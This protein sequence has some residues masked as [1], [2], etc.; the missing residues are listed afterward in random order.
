MK[1]M[2]KTATGIGLLVVALAWAG[3]EWLGPTDD[4]GVDRQAGFGP[5]AGGQAVSGMNPGAPNGQ[6]WQQPPPTQSVQPMQAM[7][8]QRP[9]VAPPLDTRS[10]QA[11]Q[12]LDLGISNPPTVAIQLQIPAGWSPVGGI[13]WNDQT[14]CGGNQ[15]QVNWIALAPDSLT[16][17]EVL[18]GFTWQVAGTEQQFN[19]CPVA[20]LRSAREFLEA[21][22]RNL[23]PD[24]QLV[25]YQDV[26]P[27]PP[28]ANEPPPAP[29]AQVRKEGGRL[30]IAYS[31]NGIAM[32]EILSTTV[33]F[34]SMQ[35]SVM[36]GAGMV[37]ALRAPAGRLDVGLLN[38]I[39]ASA[40]T[41]P[42]WLAAVNERVR[43]SVERHHAGVTA[44]IDDWHNREMATINARG[45]AERHA[46]RM[47][48]NQEVA[49]IYS[50]IAANTSATN[51]GIHRR[52]LE[53][54]GEYNTFN[55]TNG[56][57]VQNSIHNGQRVFQDT[58]N[59]NNTF[60]TNQPYFNPPGGYVEL[61]RRR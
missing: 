58:N 34:S 10:M 22:A 26:A 42:Q 8:P 48:T 13:T 53:A 4:T 46:I 30:H 56:T 17:V 19:P 1:S 41:N 20:P 18:T 21:M 61:E 59:P 29:G 5:V 37:D 7:Q 12:I 11:A 51:D 14:P 43:Q 47:R 31:D 52:S 23:R 9:A 2:T 45:M 25:G 15:V 28:T 40:Q 16:A 60:S 32:E 38:R 36:G 39:G 57:T 54:I 24:A 49:N 33:T 27:K 35:G 3:F 6:Q 44:K 55:G 50:S